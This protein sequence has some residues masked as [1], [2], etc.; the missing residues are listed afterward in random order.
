VDLLA[1]VKRFDDFQQS[2]KWIGVP[3]AVLKKFSDD[4]A[5]N[6]AALVA[7][8]A[9]VSLFPLLL[10]MTTVLG[11]VLHG[12]PDAQKEVEKSVL[13]QFPVIGNQIQLHSLTGK[14]S[15]LVIGLVVTLF[16]ALGVTSAAQ[17]A[18]DQVWAVPR[19]ARANFL[20]SRL[21]GLALFASLGILFLISTVISGFASGIHGPLG[22][23]AV[24]AAGLLLNLSLFSASFRFLTSDTVPTRCLWIGVAF[25]ACFWTL[26]QIVGGIYINHVVRHASPVGEQFALVIGLLLWLHLGAQVTLYAAEINVVLARKLWPRSLV[27]PPEAAA[28][29]KTLTALAKVE[30][31]H[32]TEQVAVTFAPPDESEPSEDEAAAARTGDRAPAGASSTAATSTVRPQPDSPDRPRGTASR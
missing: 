5:G 24:I 6:L 18:F 19:K 10:V 14:V 21:R 4:S 28:D 25:A 23:I 1:P 27:G 17:N 2:H 29:E 9:F 30:E 32:D 12:N 20:T 13:G 3:M 11:F 31:R 26:L 16:G 7:Y 8:Y 22:K 15:S